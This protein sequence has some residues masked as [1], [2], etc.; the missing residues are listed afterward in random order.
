MFPLCMTVGNKLVL[1]ATSLSVP[2]NINPFS[3]FAKSIL[4]MPNNSL[5]TG[6]QNYKIKGILFIFLI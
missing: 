6:L 4:V 5:L 2:S 1:I 3:I